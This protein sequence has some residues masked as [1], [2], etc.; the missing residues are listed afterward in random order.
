MSKKEIN[1]IEVWQI[2]KVVKN[3]FLTSCKNNTKRRILLNEGEL[4]EI[5]FPTEWYFRTIDEMFFHANTK[6][7]LHCCELFWVIYENVRFNNK[8]SL[9]EVVRLKL[10][11][12]AHLF[13]NLIKNKI[14]FNP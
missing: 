10:Y 5:R 4:I 7:I 11:D 2:R 14:I 8:A 12:G 1:R 6:D 9:E 13:N 3:G